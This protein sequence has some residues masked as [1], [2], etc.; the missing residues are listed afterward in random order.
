MRVD[1]GSYGSFSFRNRFFN[2]PRFLSGLV[3][4]EM[5]ANGC[6]VG[7]YLETLRQLNSSTRCDVYIVALTF[8]VNDQYMI[9]SVAGVK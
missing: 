8:F 7:I 4:F 9:G 6:P 2:L 3:K 1:Y 5:R